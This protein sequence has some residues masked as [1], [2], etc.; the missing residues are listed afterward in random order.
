M[1]N[2]KKMETKKKNM[3]K[4]HHSALDIYHQ[5]KYE[6]LIYPHHRASKTGNLMLSE[7]YM[8]DD[9]DKFACKTLKC[10]F[11][12][13]VEGD[14]SKTYALT[15]DMIE[16][17][18][19]KITKPIEMVDKKS[20]KIV[21][22]PDGTCKSWKGFRYLPEKI[23]NLYD[24]IQPTIPKHTCDSEIEL[25]CIIAHALFIGRG[26]CW[27]SGQPT[28]GKTSIFETLNKV[29]D[30]VPVIERPKTVPAFYRYIPED[31]ILVLD[32]TSKKDSEAAFNI[33]YALNIH[34]DM[35]KTILRMNTGGSSAYGTNVPK[36][37]RNSSCVC[38]CNRKFDY[39]DMFKFIH[40]MFPNNPAMHRRFLALRMPD[41]EV[42]MA[43]F[44]DWTKYSKSDDKI[45]VNMNK[46]ML[47][48]KPHKVDGKY[49]AGY[50]QECNDVWVN[51][52]LEEHKERFKQSHRATIKL[53]LRTFSIYHRHCKA[54]FKVLCMRL[55]QWI[56]N[57]NIM[58]A[59]DGIS[60]AIEYK[61]EE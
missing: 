34:A 25:L 46:S 33:Q 9:R 14:I 13:K 16:K 23:Y 4:L 44:D 7:F 60:E 57:Y 37:L 21:Y 59:T 45:L 20:D 48:Y 32:E 55:F 29:Y 1:N 52:I 26:A 28:S 6:E 15:K 31:G 2:L 49:V 58:V 47:W 41:G 40:Y 24:L 12:T 17:L 51:E 39:N 30:N 8:P 5:E 43:Q 61:D 38:I 22:I 42:D 10:L 11:Y 36:K 56:D 27:I 19:I 3:I 35:G 50:E 54:K 18:P 53:I